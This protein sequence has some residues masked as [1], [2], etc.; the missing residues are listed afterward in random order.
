MST[1]TNVSISDVIKAYSEKYRSQEEKRF[2]AAVITLINEK[3]TSMKKIPPEL[4]VSIK[5]ISP[6]N[7][8]IINV[9]AN[10]TA[11]T[12]ANGSHETALS[13]DTLRKILT[14]A[15]GQEKEITEKNGYSF[16]FSLI[17]TDM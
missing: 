15:G 6:K 14:N 16:V 8:W 4:L 12:S 13:S 11:S 7:A 17:P 10:S 2:S 5:P 1:N 9:S 3:L